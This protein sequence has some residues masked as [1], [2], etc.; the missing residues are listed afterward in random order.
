MSAITKNNP[1]TGQDWRKWVGITVGVA[2]L[3]FLASPNGPLGVFWRPA[4]GLFPPPSNGQLF[5]LVLLNIIEVVTF[6]LGISFVIFGYPLVR[7]AMPASKGL[8]LATYLSIAWLLVS[9]WPHDS[10]HFATGFNLNALIA[11][12]YAFHVSLMVTGAVLA[13]F[14]FALLRQRATAPR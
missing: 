1:T 8:T 4:E 14:F 9:W 10:L 12:E 2:V 3:A 11:L 5:M 13:Y 7:N 6:G